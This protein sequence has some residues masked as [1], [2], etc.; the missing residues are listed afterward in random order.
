MREWTVDRGGVEKSSRSG[1]RGLAGA[2]LSV[3][4]DTSPQEGWVI[5]PVASDPGS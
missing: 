5:V 4:N 1:W 3:P 2:V